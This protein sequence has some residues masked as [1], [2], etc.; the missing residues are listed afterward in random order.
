MQVIVGHNFVTQVR[1]IITCAICVRPT[2]PV[3]N[4]VHCIV[5]VYHAR[6]N[7][8]G[9]E[10]ANFGQD[11]NTYVYIQSARSSSFAEPSKA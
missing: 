7:W 10:I 2:S 1:I 8:S 6:R 5:T 3:Y 4:Y 9:H 11:C